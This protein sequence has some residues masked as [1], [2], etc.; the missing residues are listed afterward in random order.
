MNIKPIAEV[1]HF[2]KE[3]RQIIASTAGKRCQLNDADWAGGRENKTRR[4]MSETGYKKED[5]LKVINDLNVHNYSYTAPDVNPNFPNENVW[6]FGTRAEIVDKDYDLYI[7]LKIRNIRENYLVLMSFHPEEPDDERK[8][9]R[10][11]Y[12]N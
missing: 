4:F 6:V 2:L 10:F 8:K 11:P 5:M 3:A 9:L 12:S 7:K 1:E